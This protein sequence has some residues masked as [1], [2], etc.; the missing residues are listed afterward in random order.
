MT[1]KKP[2]AWDGDDQP[3]CPP[4]T[5]YEAIAEPVDTGIVDGNGT[6]IFR[7]QRMGPIG[8]DLS[9]KPTPVRKVHKTKA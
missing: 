9:P 5:V 4:L 6:K 2:A 8:F 3:F 1:R 7:R